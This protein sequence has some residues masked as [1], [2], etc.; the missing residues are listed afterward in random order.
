MHSKSNHKQNKKTILEWEK[1][2]ANKWL[3]RDSSPRC[4][5]THA[6]QLKTKMGGRSKEIFFQRRHAD[7]QKA[8]EHR[9]TS[10]IIT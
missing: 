7:G 10:L 8:H 1:I 5:N 2:F 3:T 9:S 6:A 4:A